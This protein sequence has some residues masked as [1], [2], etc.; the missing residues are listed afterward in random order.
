VRGITKKCAAL[1]GAPAAA[2]W[3]LCRSNA[4]TNFSERNCVAHNLQVAI[5]KVLL[6]KQI[7]H[8]ASKGFL[9]TAVLTGP[10]LV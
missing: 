8:V 6:G 3:L 2:V 10:R 4:R 1:S 7:E 9:L 5:R